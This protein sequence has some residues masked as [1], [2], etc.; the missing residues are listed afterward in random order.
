MRM[1][2]EE[3]TAA[4]IT[5]DLAYAAVTSAFIAAANGSG[6]VFPAVIAHDA[7]PENRFS[8]KSASSADYA[9]LKVGS[10]WPGNEERGIPRH[11]T[12]ILLLDQATGSP[13][14]ILE[15]AQVNAFRTS[16]ADA[17]AAD[18]LARPDASVVAVFGTGHQSLY[19]CLALARV[20]SIDVVEVV[21]RDPAKG[22]GFC[23][24]LREHGLDARL[25]H[26]REACERAD[27]VTCATT[28]T[29]PLFD[30]EW[31]RPGTHV[32]SI[33]SDAVGK[34]ELPTA[35]FAR[36]RL[37]CDLPSQ[38]VVIGEFQHIAE[39]V[40]TGAVALTAIGDVLAGVAPGRVQD[41]D[42]TVFDSSGIALQDLA[43]AVALVGMVD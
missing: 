36:A 16:A 28:A 42:I 35:L 20:R 1:L 18:A 21:A 19:N 32:A 2:T 9:G 23:A 41:A 38:S 8:I 4:L 30:A 5:H 22:E 37:F 26:P 7:D 10:Y 33:G 34:Q 40:E 25:S 14:W 17:V 43:V 29:A 12:T 6:T 11:R 3:Q 31:I 24:E 39:D 27:I 13:A 15:A